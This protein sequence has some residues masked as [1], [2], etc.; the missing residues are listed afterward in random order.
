MSSSV[1]RQGVR[2][3]PHVTNKNATGDIHLSIRTKARWE[4][5]K[6]IFPG[7]P[8]Y[9]HKFCGGFVNTT[10]YSSYNG[11]YTTP[12]R[13]TEDPSVATCSLCLQKAEQ[14]DYKVSI[15]QISNAPNLTLSQESIDNI[16][17]W[18][19]VECS[20]IIEANKIR[21][22]DIATD[23]DIE[24]KSIQQ[25]CLLITDK[26]FEP[27]SYK[28][29]MKDNGAIST[30]IFDSKGETYTVQG[31]NLDTESGKFDGLILRS[32]K[33]TSQLITLTFSE[34][35]YSGFYFEGGAPC[36]SYLKDREPLTQ[37]EI[38]ET[39]GIGS[40]EEVEPIV[41]EKDDSIEV[42]EDIF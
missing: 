18:I 22:V 39:L 42:M 7:V 40:A 41:D 21:L 6:E 23:E 28:D 4:E 36:G 14:L 12:S 1:S 29:V 32:V 35:F 30:K 38:Q 10:Q 15:A 37:S 3:D 13:Y 19:P 17:L 34:L 31:L 16:E 8:S 24:V 20:I 9:K 11:S 25:A 27:M 33:K 5:L 26:C 2:F